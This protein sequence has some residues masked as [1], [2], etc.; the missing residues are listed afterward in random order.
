MADQ[1]P[2][3]H[4]LDIEKTFHHEDGKS[5]RRIRSDEK[6]IKNHV[7]FLNEKVNEAPRSGNRNDW[8]YVGSMTWQH[9]TEFL[10]EQGRRD[11]VFYDFSHFATN[12]NGIKD[13]FREKVMPQ[14]TALQ[15][16]V[17]TATVSVPAD[18]MRQ[19]SNVVIGGD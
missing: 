9:I 4:A 16:D 8:R 18:I 6:A 13:I 17:K 3:G 15:G 12:T 11:G 5:Y 7:R 1:R 10:E 14:Y 2:L 19:A